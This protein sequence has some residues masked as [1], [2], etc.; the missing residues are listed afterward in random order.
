MLTLGEEFGTTMLRKLGALPPVGPEV[1][2]PSSPCS[3]AEYLRFVAATPETR[4]MAS[5]NE[6]PAA[7]LLMLQTE[8][9]PSA[10]AARN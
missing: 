9:T 8:L 10:W 5:V 2:D 1:D 3:L 4:K 6:V 7:L